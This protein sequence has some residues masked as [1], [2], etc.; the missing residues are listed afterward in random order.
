MVTRHAAYTR[1]CTYEGQPIPEMF[2]PIDKTFA[3]DESTKANSRTGKKF[4]PSSSPL[5]PNGTEHE[6][7]CERCL[8]LPVANTRSSSNTESSSSSESSRSRLRPVLARAVTCSPDT[9]SKLKPHSPSASRNDAQLPSVVAAT[10][11]SPTSLTSPPSSF[12]PVARSLACSPGHKVRAS[13]LQSPARNNHSLEGEEDMLAHTL[14]QARHHSATEPMDT[15]SSSGSASSAESD[16]DSAPSDAAS[17][18]SDAESVCS[19][20]IP[21]ARDLPQKAVR[22]FDFKPSKGGVTDQTSGHEAGALPCHKKSRST[23]PGKFTLDYHAMD[24]THS[25][26]NSGSGGVEAHSGARFSGYRSFL[27]FSQCKAELTVAGGGE[28]CTRCG[29]MVA[30]SPPQRRASHNQNAQ[31]KS[32]EVGADKTEETF[33]MVDG[34]AFDTFAVSDPVIVQRIVKVR[35]ANSLLERITL[36]P[37]L[38]FFLLVFDSS[39]RLSSTP[40]P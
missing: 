9:V 4:R 13:P 36:I 38:S 25:S 20:G 34:T 30:R 37:F 10:S 15:I 3:P 19:D 7:V 6:F 14:L 24:D 5:K 1:C 27:E 31:H 29:K 22:I 40:L 18:D 23:L 2:S 35:P 39:R 33:S 8:S 26:R 12:S 11:P 21:S 17:V 16:S 28:T 32:S